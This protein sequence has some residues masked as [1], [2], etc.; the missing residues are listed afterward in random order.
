MY[1]LDL[2]EVRGENGQCDLGRAERLQMIRLMVVMLATY[3]R[4]MNMVLVLR[5]ISPILRNGYGI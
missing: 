5:G 3:S 4:V 2:F 1:L